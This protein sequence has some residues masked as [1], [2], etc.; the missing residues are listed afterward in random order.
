MTIVF[1][2]LK[3]NKFFHC[4]SHSHLQNPNVKVSK[5]ESLKSFSSFTPSSNQVLQAPLMN[6]ELQDLVWKHT[7]IF[8]I[9]T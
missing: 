7:I 3:Q 8:L 6:S 5:A 9:G 1:Q 4:L 2:S